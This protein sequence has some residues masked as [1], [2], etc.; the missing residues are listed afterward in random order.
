MIRRQLINFPSRSIDYRV[1]LGAFDEL[2]RML[3]SAVGRPKRA[4][5]V[6]R[7]DAL[8][9]HGETVRRS[10]TDAGFAFEELTFA[11][12]EALCDLAH[13]DALFSALGAANI[14]CDDLIVALG[15]MDVCSLVSWASGMWCGRTECALIPVTFD[16]MV[17]CATSMTPLA[18]SGSEG[19][20]VLRPEPAVVV[21][22]LDL[23]RA[24][25][26]EDLRMG[27][28][29]LV[30]TILSSSRSRWNQFLETI[31]DILA[32]EEV[33]LLNCLQWAQSARKDVLT[34]TN[35]SAQHALHFGEAGARALKT[36]LGDALE[37]WQLLAEGM[38]FEARLAH[39]ACDFDVD[40]VFELDDCLDDLGVE[41]AA[42]SLEPAAFVEAFH[43]E[44]F[45][46][47]NRMMLPL[48]ACAGAI[49]LAVVEDEVLERHA[50][51]Y[52]ASRAELLGE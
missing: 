8:E 12:D 49:R 31:P 17:C 16:A 48:P 29:R 23:V 24:A 43:T 50:E 41:E 51:A 34:A 1:G 7:A 22:D 42:F 18:A 26:H 9:A 27:Y 15:D 5:L 47:S 32:G 21:C 40:E 13:A 11:A 33:A 28:V 3:T 10:L 52:L 4:L 2:P 37:P 46:R 44:H 38:R 6:A 36:L 30:G 45:R 19:L 25:S 20:I 39:D 14:T 35:P